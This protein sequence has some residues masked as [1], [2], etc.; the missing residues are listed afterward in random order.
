MLGRLQAMPGVTHAA[1]SDALPLAPVDGTR[2]I[3]GRNPVNPGQRMEGAIHVVGTDYVAAMG[4][5]MVACAIP[6]RCA[7]RIDAIEALR[8]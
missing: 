6:A 3:P 2:E 4:I 5:A 8:R 1:L 7:A